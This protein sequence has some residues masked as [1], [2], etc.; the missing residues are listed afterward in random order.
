MIFHLILGGRSVSLVRKPDLL[1]K[2]AGGLETAV[3]TVF[4]LTRFSLVREEQKGGFVKGWFWR[5]CP[6]SGFRSRGTCER[7][8]VPVF[9]L[10]KHPK[11][12]FLFWGNI[13]MYPHSGFRSGGT[14]A[15]TTLLENHLFVNPRYNNESNFVCPTKS[16]LITASL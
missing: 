12:P 1:T 10:G 7:T 8:R 2:G 4:A 11:V 6:R 14:S 3:G 15:K 5:M 16:A 9:V 13:R